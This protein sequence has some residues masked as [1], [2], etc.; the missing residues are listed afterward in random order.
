MRHVLPPRGPCA[1]AARTAVAF[2]LLRALPL[3]AVVTLEPVGA[4]GFRVL[5]DG[6]E[7]VA[8][9]V[10][11]L[12]R[13][14]PGRR[15]VYDPTARVFREVEY[16]ASQSVQFA[17]SNKRGEPVFL[18]EGRVSVTR[19]RDTILFRQ[20]FE[21][22]GAE[23]SLTLRPADTNGL[24][25]E[26]D[27][28]VAPAFRIT[29][30]DA[31]VLSLNLRGATA[32]SGHLGQ[33]RRA[34]PT[35]RGTLVGPHPGPV[36]IQY[37]GN[38][39]YAPAAVLQ[40]ARLAVGL[41]RL[42]VHDVWRAPFGELTLTPRAEAV[43]LRIATGWAEAVSLASL[44][45]S[46]FRQR[47]R[48]RFAAARPP[49]PAGYL[50]LTDA[51]DLW[52]DYLRE[53]EEH[54]PIQ[55]NPPY[56]RTRNPLV[57]MNYFMAE[58]HLVTEQNP[59][60]WVMADP[61]WK[62]NRWEFPARAAEATGKELEALTGFSE[63]HAGRP[64]NWIRAYAEKN[65]REMRE[66][67]ALANV[68]WRSATWAGA[69]NLSLD[70]LPDTQY[71]HPDME[72]RCAV[73]GPVRPWDWAVADIEVTAPDHTVIARQSGVA[74]HAVNRDSLRRLARY[75]DMR[76][77]L[78]FRDSEL[79]GAAAPYLARAAGIGAAERYRDFIRLYLRLDSAADA[80]TGARPGA[81][82]ALRAIPQLTDP[83]LASTG[84]TVRATI[85]GVRRAAIDVWAKTLTDAGCE[86]GFLIRED[87]LMGPPWHMTFMRLD[88]TSEW[89]YG[90]FRQRVEWHRERFGERC[91]W[92]YLDV[93]ANETPDFVLQ[94]MRRDFPDCFFFAEHPNGVAL[95]TI[96]V[97]NWFG[98][99]TPLE[100]MLNPGG[101][102]ILLPERILTDD[103]EANR[104]FIRS[105]WRHPNYLYVT[106]RG[107]RRL[108]SLA[109]EAGMA[110][111]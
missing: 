19:T 69:H 33:W 89:Q 10:P 15:Q 16:G 97:W 11:A 32:D 8:P 76:Q 7:V 100:R 22:A 94:R 103:Q 12:R 96:Q 28:R 93:F 43:E 5:W 66:T 83:A 1:A 60:G 23:W 3:Q 77:R 86:I 6:V 74:L 21:H 61:S 87:F 24:D 42:G 57:I 13:L 52:A 26:L 104:A 73:E 35:T 47:Y 4:D 68:V 82:V 95:R 34:L 102:A 9:S 98:P 31:A 20:R 40:D 2:A 54:V 106:H 85:R 38:N 107:A 17:V 105:T 44:H 25:L 51:P 101:L 48:L 90:L 72:E 110:T 70:Y 49:G 71:F 50:Q 92:F 78:G 14:G 46:R 64:V 63:S 39:L 91:R 88:W 108:V 80:L 65:L 84:L 37:P 99:F 18:G 62:S 56:D 36:R 75:E 27:A 55:P 109:R 45:E 53:L 41:C 67:R 79:T 59:Q 30:L 58:N 111:E 29:A 81:Q